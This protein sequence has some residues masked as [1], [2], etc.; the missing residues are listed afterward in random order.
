MNKTV[1]MVMTACLLL[2]LSPSL[3]AQREFEI[4]ISVVDIQ[5]ETGR[6]KAIDMGEKYAFAVPC[7]SIIKWKCDYPFDLVF[8]ENAPFEALAGLPKAKSLK[9]MIGAVPNRIYKYTIVAFVGE[10]PIKLD[11]IIIIIPPRK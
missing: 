5:D 7:E 4:K 6:K 11:P 3:P 10:E 9:P 2:C 8:E 1:V